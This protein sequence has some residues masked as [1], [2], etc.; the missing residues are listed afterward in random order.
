MLR[1]SEKTANVLFPLK[2]ANGSASHSSHFSRSRDDL[3]LSSSPCSS[4]NDGV[5]VCPLTSTAH[6][7]FLP[8]KV[9]P[10]QSNHSTSHTNQQ[11]SKPLFVSAVSHHQSGSSGYLTC[12]NVG[13][14]T[15][16]SPEKEGLVFGSSK[17]ACDLGSAISLLNTSNSVAKMADIISH[18]PI[19]GEELEK[20]VLE[21]PCCQDFFD[22]KSISCCSQQHD[23][24]TYEHRDDTSTV[25]GDYLSVSELI[26]LDKDNNLDV[27][28]LLSDSAEVQSVCHYSSAESSAQHKPAKPADCHA[29]EGEPSVHPH[30]LSLQAL[31]RRSQECRRRQR[32][33]RNQAKNAK[34][35]EK[36]QARTRTEDPSL[37]DKENDEF[38][39]KSSDTLEVKRAKD[40]RGKEKTLPKEPGE[41]QRKFAPKFFWEKTNCNSE[42]S[43]S[44]RDGSSSGRTETT[45]ESSP[46]SALLDVDTKVT[47]KKSPIQKALHLIN[48]PAGFYRGG[49]YNTIPVPNV[50]RSPICFGSTFPAKTER[51]QAVF[52]SSDREAGEE[53]VELVAPPTVQTV[54]ATSSLHIDQLELNLCSL[55]AMI[56]DLESTLTENLGRQYQSEF[57][58]QGSH[59]GEV[60][61][62]GRQLVE[63]ETDYQQEEAGGRPL[64]ECSSSN[65]GMF[66][67]ELR[68]ATA[69][70]NQPSAE[71]VDVSELR[72]VKNIAA[73]RA[74]EKVTLVTNSGRT[75]A[76]SLGQQT[77]SHRLQIPQVLQVVPS[78]GD[79]ARRRFPTSSGGPSEGG[80]SESRLVGCVGLNQSYDVTS[81]SNLWLLEASGPGLENTLTPESGSEGQGVVSKV[82]RRLLMHGTE[83]TTVG[84]DRKVNN[85]GIGGKTWKQT[86]LGTAVFCC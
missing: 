70:D 46:V 11:E 2:N 7:A 47:Q 21:S 34:I 64:T 3:V 71:A 49:N 50:S 68:R 19:D 42:S 36:T 25:S 12:E 20:S 57:A 55:K 80:R 4:Q 62:P 72:L 81:P 82:K 51:T 79:D 65:L 56:S 26:H 22:V 48:S 33:L 53:D 83:E 84:S 52:L 9:T 45:F 77:K 14:T 85:S 76:D 35:Q 67:E 58:F 28:S 78:E 24:M 18:P 66:A 75:D 63:K 38:L 8:S 61:P 41:Y 69:S 5:S 54:S 16:A 44:G 73:Q 40:N 1:E 86:T 43:H 39:P 29:G 13:N 74:K 37:S 60:N 32:M 31:L 27:N 15:G 30:R 10:R 59:S 6:S 23:S 17:V